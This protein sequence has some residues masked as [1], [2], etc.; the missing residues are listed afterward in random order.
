MKLHKSTA[1]P[2]APK[3]GAAAPAKKPK[4]FPLVEMTDGTLKVRGAWAYLY[5]LPAMLLFLVFTLY[6]LAMVLRTAFYQKYQ[7][8]TNTGTGFGLHS[9]EWV[10][11]D[12]TFWLAVKNTVILLLIALPITLVLALGIALLLNSIKKLQGLF[13]TIFFLPYVT[14]TIAVGMAFLWLF[15]VDYGYINYFLGLFGIEPQKW[16]TDP[17]LM[18]VSLSIFSVWNGLAFKILLFLAGLQ[19][20]DK[21]VYQAAKI[22]SSTPA[23]TLFKITLPLLSPTIWMVILVSVIYVARTFNEV[24]AMFVSFNGGT[25]GTGNGAITVMY[26]IYW[27]F[28]DQG[29][30]NYAAAAAIIFLIVILLI[31]VLQR[32]IS[33][34]FVH[35]V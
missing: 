8:I 23:R 13:Q 14:S 19:K 7:Y 4:R 1:D 10:L 27:M 21:Q 34:K 16:L 11:S 33:K 5:I 28:Y 18:I 2:A 20:I 24:Y 35:Y 3:A 26:Y 6:P 30:V 29:K 31:T 32:V 9:F 15:H 12:S 17:N 22:D 25:A